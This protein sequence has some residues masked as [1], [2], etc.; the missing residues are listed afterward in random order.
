MYDHSA[1]ITWDAPTRLGSGAELV[2]YVL[3]YSASGEEDV[4]KIV[5]QENRCELTDLAMDTVYT[6]SAK[7]LW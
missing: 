7:V 3:Q 4:K 5:I 1:I 6:F 2:H